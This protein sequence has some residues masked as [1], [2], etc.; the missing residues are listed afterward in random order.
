MNKNLEKRMYTLALYSLSGIQA[1]IQSGHSWIDFGRSARIG[2]NT[3]QVG[4]EAWEMY[5][6]WEANW[7][8]VY[9]MNGGSSTILE[10]SLEYISSL[11][12]KTCAFIEPDIYNKMSCFSLLVDERVFDSRKHPDKDIS[13]KELALREFLKSLSFHGG[14]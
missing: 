13:P 8:T 14:K 5:D 4:K 6:D 3:S 1:G 12:V 7:K 2:A 9:V 11:G 10:E